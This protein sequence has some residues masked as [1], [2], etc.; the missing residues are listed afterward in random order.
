VNDHSLFP[1]L[2]SFVTVARTGSVG[3]AARQR[4]RTSSA[5]SQQ[6]RRLESQ[7]GVKLLERAGRGVRLTP[8]GEAALPMIDR[9][10]ADADAL[11]SSLTTLAGHPVTTIRVAA[12][13]YLGK[14]LL[15]PVL[16][17]LLDDRS[18]VRFEIVTTHSRDAV[19]RV[20]RGDIDFGVVSAATVPAGLDARHLFDQHFAWVG[21]KRPASRRAPLLE[22]LASE[23]LLRLGAESHGRRLLEE[24]FDR[25]RL[26]PV[27]TIDVTSVSLMLAY[28]T[29]GIGVGLVPGL[30]LRDLPRSRVVI[31]PADV[32]SLPVRLV[33]RRTTRRSAAAARFAGV[34][35]AEARRVAGQL[36]RV[37]VPGPG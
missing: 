36:P 29:G 19:V 31:E 24:F 15:V 30:A 12:S 21:P 20:A 11:F 28:I 10:W 27:S 6:V 17:A 26:R 5:I 2:W 8:A 3:A 9:L 22:R 7:V 25:R 37:A 35:E 14:A 16:R 33:S 4:H 1:A 32:P 23:P 13:D 18:P 34:L